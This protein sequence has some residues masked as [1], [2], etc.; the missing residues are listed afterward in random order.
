MVAGLTPDSDFINA[1]YGENERRLV[2]GDV[3]GS[4][5]FFAD[6]NARFCTP[7]CVVG[8]EEITIGLRTTAGVFD[9]A[10]FNLTSIVADDGLFLVDLV[11][12]VK[13]GECTACNNKNTTQNCLGN[14]YLLGVLC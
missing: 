1:F 8:K 14:V 5:D 4:I 11:L 6:D 9:C 3:S 2:S 10:K 7:G 13:S 12:T